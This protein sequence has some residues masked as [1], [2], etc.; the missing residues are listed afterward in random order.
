MT[1]TLST[2]ERADLKALAMSATQ[3]VC[4]PLSSPTG[5]DMPADCC[6]YAVVSVAMS[7]E[8]CRVWDE[9]DVRFYAA[10]NPSVVLSLLAALEEAEGRITVL[11]ECVACDDE[12][13]RS[14]WA[15]ADELRA[16]LAES[17]ATIKQLR[18]DCEWADAERK[19][20]LEWAQSATARAE[21]AEQQVKALEK[22]LGVETINGVRGYCCHD[23]CSCGGDLPAIRQTCGSWFT[24]SP[25]KSGEN[26]DQ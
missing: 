18:Q 4:V 8:T 26:H 9:A 19:N 7:R 12:S 25:S 22:L 2:E 20:N 3:G 21:K 13:V 16:S 15:R 5:Y 23:H 14:A 11:T 17:E 6:K 10:A 1:D 24:L